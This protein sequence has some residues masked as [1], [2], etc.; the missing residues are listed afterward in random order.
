MTQHIVFLLLGLGSGAVFGALALGLVVTYRSSGVVNFAT[1]AIALYTAYTYAFL[2]RGELLLPIPGLPKTVSVGSDWGLW[3]A[4]AVSLVIAA[5]LGVLLYVLV[6]R[7]LRSA[8]PVA[9]AVASIGLL[10]VFQALLAQRVGTTPVSVKRILPSENYTIGDLRIQGDKL[11]FA[12]TIVV[13]AL[14]LAGVF[15][16][17]RFGLATRAAAETEK[18]ALVTGLSPDRIALANWAIGAVVA[19]LSGI[20]ISPIVPLIPVSYT[21]FIVPALAAALVAGFNSLGLAVGAGL[22]IGM[23]Q[24]ELQF[25]QS[26]HSWLPQ[27]GL[28]QLVPLVVILAY[29]VLRGRPLPTRGMLI[30]ANLGQAPRPRHRL[31]NIVIPAVVAVVLLVVT[32]GSMRAAVVTSMLLGIVTLSLVVVT[33]YAGQVSLA[34][35]TL[36]GVGG[37]LVSRMTT[38]WN[39]PFPIAPLLAALG[40]MVI[41]VVVGLPALR[42][43]GLPVAV[44]TL[45]LGMAVESIWFRNPDVN[46][47][48]GGAKVADPKLWGLNL[49]IGAGE[50]YPRIQFGLLCLVVLIGVGLA[51]AELRRS[52]LGAAMLAV[53]A[54]ERSAAAAGIDVARVKIAAFAIGSFIAGLGGALMAYQQTLVDAESFSVVG[55]LALF[56][57]AYLAG[58][59]SVSGG[60]LAGVLGA[61]GLLF[62]ALDK[63][64]DLGSWYQVI[65]GLA[66]VLSVL[67]NPEGAVGPVHAWWSGRRAKRLRAEP[68]V[69]PTADA[70]PATLPAEPAATADA[71]RI[72]LTLRG[73]GVRYGGVRAVQDVS[74]DFGQGQ[75]I[76][77][78]GPNGAGKTTLIDAISGFTSATGEVEFEG[79][80]LDGLK[81]HHRIR[82]GLG[83]TF[84]GIEL[85]EDLSVAENVTVGEAAARG[86]GG[87]LPADHADHLD[88]LYRTLQLH[89]VRDRPVREL[90]QGHR[91]LVS[92]ARALAGRPRVLLLDEPA[93]GLDSTESLWLGERLREVARTGVTIV[94]VDHDMNLVLGV[95]DRIVVLALGAVIASGSPEEIKNHPAVAEAYLG[96]AP[97]ATT[98]TAPGPSP[99]LA[100][101]SVG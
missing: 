13:L 61:G 33:G 76:G 9:K 50:N 11:W 29:L 31:L 82:T 30:R 91:Q 32:S 21:L 1:G 12:L 73:V 46:G 45:A 18:G 87:R 53:R 16:F 25:L 22:L 36:A 51:V 72:L 71:E 55:G 68:P 93:G 60:L 97:V 74:L 15:R 79:V 2:R 52:R 58:I 17:T 90:S 92:I 85:Y 70:I 4:L 77:L 5:L 75:V 78:I 56:A 34:Q 39:I 44:V 27:Q 41:G 95:C 94:L 3:P 37:F 26:Q 40:A 69:L 86:G 57:T 49:R 10:I 83:R 89:E 42:I 19:G 63:A 20:L 28:G 67:L 88:R 14:A 96:S 101:E 23:V 62:V 6:F 48:T 59:T 24:S 100:K 80:R 7:W 99:S 98:A 64:V 47:G 38:D 43:R 81:P 54:N 65:T 84:Q 8:P 66:L 35:L